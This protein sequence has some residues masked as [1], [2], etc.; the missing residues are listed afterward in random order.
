MN[1]P[2]GKFISFWS[3]TFLVT[4]NIIVVSITLFLWKYLWLNSNR[5]NI[6]YN[7]KLQ[8]EWRIFKEEIPLQGF[9]E[10]LKLIKTIVTDIE[11]EYVIKKL[12][13]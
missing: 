12:G 5:L 11:S 9:W 6:P 7:Q 2:G 1:D 13:Y 3:F 10:T 4:G 8:P